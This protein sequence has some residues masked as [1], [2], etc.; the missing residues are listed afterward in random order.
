[1]PPI[2]ESNSA[3]TLIFVEILT[4][5]GMIVLLIKFS[6]ILLSFFVDVES[7]R[8]VYISPKTSEALLIWAA[9]DS[10]LQAA[11]SFPLAWVMG[12]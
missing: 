8:M 5:R 7:L 1:M 11:S 6:F 12:S 3:E 9:N 4:Q 10:R 2:G